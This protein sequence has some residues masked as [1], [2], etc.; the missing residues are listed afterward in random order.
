MGEYIEGSLDLPDWYYRGKAKLMFGRR[1]SDGQDS[2]AMLFAMEHAKNCDMD[3]LERNQRFNRIETAIKDANA[4]NSKTWAEERAARELQDIGN[5]DRMRSIEKAGWVQWL[6]LM[7]IL[8]S[9][10][11]AIIG[12]LL[13]I[14][15]KLPAHP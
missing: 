4:T 3:K 1:S 10:S 14:I 11:L 5:K 6:W 15:V 8:F 12:M 2:P 7:G 13:S 9:A